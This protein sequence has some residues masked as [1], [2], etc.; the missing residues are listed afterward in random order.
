MER[1]RTTKPIKYSNAGIQFLWRV[2]LEGDNPVAYTYELDPAAK[3]YVPTGI[4]REHLRTHIGFD[5]DIDLDFGRL[6]A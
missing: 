1:D 5:V 4:H 2:E 3:A 6:L